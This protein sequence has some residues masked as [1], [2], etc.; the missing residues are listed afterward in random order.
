M[1]H[2]VS[3]V[4]RHKASLVVQVHTNAL[5]LLMQWEDS[6]RPCPRHVLH[7]IG[8]RDGP[9]TIGRQ[10][11]DHTFPGDRFSCHAHCPHCAAW[12]LYFPVMTSVGEALTAEQWQSGIKAL[13]V[14]PCRAVE[15]LVAH[16]G[17]W[18]GHAQP[19]VRCARVERNGWRH[20]TQFIKQNNNLAC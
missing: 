15:G 6:W 5:Q 3:I 7:A 20:C 13:R 14:I 18:R 4:E 11:F 8:E 10:C 17:E 16:A 2:A 12:H 1:C 9:E 19:W